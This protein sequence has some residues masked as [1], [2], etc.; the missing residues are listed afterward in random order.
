MQ[1]IKL[2]HNGDL[3]PCCGQ[4]IRG[5]TEAELVRYSKLV[6]AM[7]T[8][9]GLQVPAPGDGDEYLTTGLED[10]HGALRDYIDEIRAGGAS[11]APARK[12]EAGDD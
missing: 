5:K 8:F 11:P 6:A 1:R 7:S 2:Y 10:L 3:C 9:W 4:V 12:T